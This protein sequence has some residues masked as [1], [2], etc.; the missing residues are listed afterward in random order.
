MGTEQND[1]VRLKKFCNVAHESAN[2]PHRDIHAPVP[3]A[4]NL[5]HSISF[6]GHGSIVP[7][8]P[9][10]ADG[11]RSSAGLASK[12]PSGLSMKPIEETGMTGQSSGLGIWL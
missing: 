8:H 9:P 2:H 12:K 3:P 1:L 11:G 4:R 6:P 10:L 5:L 7:Q